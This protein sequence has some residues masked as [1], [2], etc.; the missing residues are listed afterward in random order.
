MAAL[1]VSNCGGG[2]FI[3]VP[4]ITIINFLKKARVAVKKIHEPELKEKKQS[5]LNKIDSGPAYMEKH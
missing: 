1:G 5:C 4:K 2:Q 3:D